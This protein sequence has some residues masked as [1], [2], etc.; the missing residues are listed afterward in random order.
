MLLIL[1][2]IFTGDYIVISEIDA[3]IDDTYNH[4]TH[5]RIQKVLVDVVLAFFFTSYQQQQ[6]YVLYITNV[7]TICLL[8]SDALLFCSALYRGFHTAYQYSGTSSTGT[9]GST[10][11]YSTTW[12]YIKKY[13]HAI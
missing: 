12:G 1:S 10:C 13:W 4:G 11:I 3:Q 2:L 8:Q 7:S 9:T 6:F 5:A